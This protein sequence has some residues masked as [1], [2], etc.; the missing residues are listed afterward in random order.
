MKIYDKMIRGLGELGF[1]FKV[2]TATDEGFLDVGG[3]FIS[4]HTES[5]T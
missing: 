5:A 3:Y 4:K 1:N 2:V